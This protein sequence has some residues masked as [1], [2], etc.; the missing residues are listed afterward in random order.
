MIV[1]WIV[2][3][4]GACEECHGQ[5]QKNNAVGGR[6]LRRTKRIR[7]HHR[8][9]DKVWWRASSDH[10]EICDQLSGSSVQWT[11]VAQSNEEANRKQGDELASNG[12]C[13][14]LASL[15]G[16]VSQG[17]LHDDLNCALR[18]AQKQGGF[19]IVAKRLD[20]NR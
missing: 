9:D 2:E 4:L 18:H 12:G 14:A 10:Q 6:F 13:S 16:N 5:A 7:R 3:H 19:G 17:Y 1:W 8:Q 15:V 11:H 20:E